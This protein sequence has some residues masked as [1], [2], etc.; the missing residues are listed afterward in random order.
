MVIINK[1]KLIIIKK[2]KWLL[3]KIDYYKKI[4]NLISII[5]IIKSYEIVVERTWPTLQE[6]LS[7]TAK[8]SK[9]IIYVKSD[10]ITLG[11]FAKLKINVKINVK[12]IIIIWE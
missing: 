2:L 12:K 3:L 10:K 5:N 7:I 8:K 1:L 11:I 4:I 9:K 6:Y